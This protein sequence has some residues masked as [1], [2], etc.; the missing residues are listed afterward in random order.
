[1]L[2]AKDVMSR[3]VITI[4][5]ETKAVEA[6]RLFARVGIS[7]APVVGPRRKLLGV[8]SETDL[9]RW[10]EQELTG[11]VPPFYREGE[12][13]ASTRPVA[14]RDVTAAD[15]MTPAVLSAR[16]DTPIAELARFMLVNRIHRVV[17][18][19][20][21][22]LRGLVTTMDLLRVLAAPPSGEA[23]RPRRPAGR[24]FAPRRRGRPSAS[25]RK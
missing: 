11:D 13:S 21:G 3:R 14:P 4:G 23:L 10:H 2:T 12:R 16:E 9:V 22:V 1:M 7:G 24:R 18:T 5:P 25:R 17:I 15:V 20:R 6:A 19:E 8:V